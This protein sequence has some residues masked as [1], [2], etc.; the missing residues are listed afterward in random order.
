MAQEDVGEIVPSIEVLR[1]EISKN[2]QDKS[3]FPLLS[4]LSKEHVDQLLNVLHNH[5]FDTSLDGL[6]KSMNDLLDSFV[7]ALFQIRS[8]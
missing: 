2:L 8:D 4:N 5:S 3:Q 6:D 1:S 7:N